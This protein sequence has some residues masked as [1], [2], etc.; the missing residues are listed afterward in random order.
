M[1]MAVPFEVIKSEIVSRLASQFSP[2]VQEA[3]SAG[4]LIQDFERGLFEGLLAVGAKVLD[5][6]LEAQGNGDQGKMI[7]HEGQRLHRSDEPVCRPLRTIFGEHEFWTYVYRA[8][9]GAKSQIV[10]RP[11]DE[12][13]GL[14]CD[15]YSPL[16][17]QFSM[18][19]CCEE[20]FHGSVKAFF[21]VFSQK[22]SVDTLEK[23]SRRMAERGETFLQNRMAPP[24]A[25]EGELLVL[26]AVA[27]GVPLV[28]KDAQ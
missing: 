21:Q 16:L 10:L 25:E 14:S 8:G 17:Q 6:F 18:L 13:L 9:A 15:R 20:A 22:L 11:V 19:F 24:P 7:A 27:K 5:E 23:V 26:T 2:L 1:S 12:R 3:A 4:I 28:K